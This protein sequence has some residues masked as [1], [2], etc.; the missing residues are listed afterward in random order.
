MNAFWNSHPTEQAQEFADARR[1][2]FQHE[3]NLEQLDEQ[4]E[5]YSMVE[6]FHCGYDGQYQ[7]DLFLENSE[8]SFTAKN[9]D[10]Y[11]YRGRC[12]LE[13]VP[14]RPRGGHLYA[15]QLE[16]MCDLFNISLGGETWGTRRMSLATGL[17]AYVTD[18]S[19]TDLES[20]D[21][22]S[23]SNLSS[24][25]SVSLSSGG[26][27]EDH[28]GG[29]KTGWKALEAAHEGSNEGTKM[30]VDEEDIEEEDAE[31]EDIEEETSDSESD[32]DFE[33]DS[34]HDSGYQTD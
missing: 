26:K 24:M 13:I 5:N 16:R 32:S 9:G 6:D 30:D 21:S 33:D 14:R 4:Q 34:E 18:A 25:T 23:L 29:G 8:R 3:A 15:D 20:D 12:F 2:K 31:E 11:R 19:L 27:T 17:V 1:W 22:S 7:L 10:T 28:R